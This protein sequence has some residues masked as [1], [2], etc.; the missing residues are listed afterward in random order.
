V[1]RRNEAGRVVLE[2]SERVLRRTC[3]RKN[4]FGVFRTGVQKRCSE[5]NEAGRV[6][7][8][9]SEQVLRKRVQKKVEKKMRQED[10]FKKKKIRHED[11]F[12]NETG[13]IVHFH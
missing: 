5:E 8:E 2:C 3:D 6:V 7:L 11:L 12:E 9:F 10:L 1:F 4:Y 13:R